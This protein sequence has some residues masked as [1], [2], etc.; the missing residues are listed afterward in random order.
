MVYEMWNYKVMSKHFRKC[1]VMIKNDILILQDIPFSL[2]TQLHLCFLEKGQLCPSF[3]L[4]D[5]N[6]YWHQ[7]LYRS[8]GNTGVPS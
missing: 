3:T 1:Q 6:F 4:K 8:Q 2:T 7:E 5:K